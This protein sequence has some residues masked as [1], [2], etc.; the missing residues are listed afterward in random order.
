MGRQARLRLVGSVAAP[1][2]TRDLFDACCTRARGRAVRTRVGFWL[3][4]GVLG[5]VAVGGTFPIPLYPVYQ[6]AFGFSMLVLSAIFAGFLVGLTVSLL[7]LGCAS[8]RLGRRIVLLAALVVAAGAGALFLEASSVPWLVAARVVSGIAVGLATPAAGAAIAEL[9]PHG[10]LHRASLLT[11]VVT[12]GGL[13]VGP[14]VSGLL[15]EYTSAPRTVP[16]VV[17][18][19]LLAAAAVALLFVPETMTERRGAMSSMPRFT[20]LPVH[21]RFTFVR[22]TA[23]AV[24]GFSAIG[25]FSSLVPSL[26]KSALGRPNHALGGLVVFS[27]YAAAAVGQVGGRRLGR[28]RA[29][30]PGLVLTAL[31]LAVVAVGFADTSISVVVLG[32]LGAGLAV[33]G[34]LGLLNAAC[35]PERRA[36]TLSAY[37]TVT[38]L[39]S[40]VPVVAA[41]FM[42]QHVGSVS[43]TVMVAGWI[44]LLVVAL[45]G[46]RLVGRAPAP[47]SGAASP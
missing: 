18:L 7:C 27:L 21:L 23:T 38:Y 46:V 17:Y 33:M 15:A 34:G 22:A 10:D 20:R 1:A 25:F 13:G 28:R 32:G 31:G 3:A 9:E 37:F 12:V 14:L 43:A 47:R 45:L 8:D 5:A 4:V 36:E 42:A 2:D 39:T 44:G 40:A 35:P 6:M 41:A 29:I 30:P 16:W 24:A 11:A 19:G 26:L